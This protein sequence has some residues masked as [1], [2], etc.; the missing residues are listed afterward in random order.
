MDRAGRTCR[1]PSRPACSC[2]QSGWAGLG[3][4]LTF[5]G[6]GLFNR[7]LT[8]LAVRHRIQ[9][10]PVEGNAWLQ[11]LMQ[12]AGFVPVAL[13]KHCGA[14]R[15]VAAGY[16]L[17]LFRIAGFCG[18][19]QRHAGGQKD[20]NQAKEA[21]SVSWDRSNHWGLLLLTVLGLGSGCVFGSAWPATA[22]QES[23]HL[24]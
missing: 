19:R 13:V 11:P 2:R 21:V 4:L 8:A 15:V 3:S 10:F 14:C 23:A 20:Q 16:P 24:Q 7:L 12:F 1:K 9:L 17:G 6:L 5:F 22:R 18:S